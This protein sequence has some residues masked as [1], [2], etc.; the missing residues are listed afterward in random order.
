MQHWLTLFHISGGFTELI[1]WVSLFY[2]IHLV[3]DILCNY[4]ENLPDNVSAS[5]YLKCCKEQKNLDSTSIGLGVKI[6]KKK[7]N[8]WKHFQSDVTFGSVHASVT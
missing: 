5:F 8:M 1:T 4:H 3:V 2:W 7:Q 6:I